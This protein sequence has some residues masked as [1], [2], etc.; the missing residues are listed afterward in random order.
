MFI[1]K[2]RLKYFLLLVVVLARLP[3]PLPLLLVVMVLVLVSVMPT[4]V[5]QGNGLSPASRCRWSSLG[6]NSRRRL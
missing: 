2:N 3:L 5:G 4:L 6:S 1:Y